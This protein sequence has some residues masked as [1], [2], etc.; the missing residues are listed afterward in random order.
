MHKQQKKAIVLLIEKNQYR[1]ECLFHL[2]NKNINYN[3]D[4]DSVFVCQNKSN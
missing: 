3:D 1:Y 4:D 2:F